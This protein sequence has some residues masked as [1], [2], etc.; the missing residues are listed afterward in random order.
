[1]TVANPWQWYVSVRTFSNSIETTLT[2][3]AMRYWPWELLEPAV[4]EKEN[5]KPRSQ[6]ANRA[7]LNQYAILASL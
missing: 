6:L 3:A 2:V 5:I 1:L 4:P 7:T